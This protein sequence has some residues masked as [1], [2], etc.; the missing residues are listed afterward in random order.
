MDCS[1]PGLPV[2]HQLPGFTQTHVHWVGD[3][4]QPSHSLSS[5]SPPTYN[6]SQLGR[7][8]VLNILFQMLIVPLNSLRNIV[9]DIPPQELTSDSFS[10]LD[11]IISSTFVSV[12]CTDKQASPCPGQIWW[13]WGG[14]RGRTIWISF[15]SIKVELLHIQ[16]KVSFQ[17][18]ALSIVLCFLEELWEELEMCTSTR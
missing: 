13:R 8:G 1:T 6:L 17:W 4:I 14:L 11:T 16:W 15:A 18:I 12:K 2:H 7:S 5:P 10:H 3:A 9:G